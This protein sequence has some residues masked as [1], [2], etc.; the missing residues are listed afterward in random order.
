MFYD[1]M[2][3]NGI[4]AHFILKSFKMVLF[5]R[6]KKSISILK[7]VKR[8]R[9]LPMEVYYGEN[10]WGRGEG[11]T[12]MQ[13]IEL[14]EKFLWG[15]LQ[16]FIPFLYVNEEG[17]AM[18]FCVRIPDDRM[19]TFIE[20]WKDKLGEPIKEE[21][22]MEFIRD[23]PLNFNFSITVRVDGEEM[24][25]DFGCGA[26]YSKK[27]F[28]AYKEKADNENFENWLK[29]DS[30]ESRLV[31]SYQC[32][33]DGSWHFYRHMCRWNNMLDIIEQL[34]IDFIAKN[35][36]YSGEGFETGPDSKGQKYEII[37]PI[38]GSKYQLEVLDMEQEKIDKEH[39]QM[40]RRKDREVE[41]P[42][43]YL[44]ILFDVPEELSKEEFCIRDSKRSD[45]PRQIRSTEDT[46][47]GIT[48]IGGSSGPTSVWIAGKVGESQKR[49]R[50]AM[51]SL[52]F[53]PVTSVIWKPVFMRK[54]REDMS[55]KIENIRL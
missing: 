34:E 5:G 55:L 49:G 40:L 50:S 14:N 25:S 37:S 47:F 11:K 8:K 20:K 45:E 28:E 9:D 21:E 41:F 24:Q 32:D 26:S 29:E 44:T 10:Y 35:V 23:N 6:N 38:D 16:G 12:P 2:D 30:L 18:D 17:L 51:S 39:L 15:D 13:K 48:V 19:E 27:L 3:T 53:E 46:A 4:R 31:R 54:E 7:E 52:H 22:Q 42:N 33:A 1:K 43:H 36:E